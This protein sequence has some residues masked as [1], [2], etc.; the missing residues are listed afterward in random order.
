[1]KKA[2]SNWSVVVAS[3]AQGD[4]LDLFL[5]V[6]VDGVDAEVDTDRQQQRGY[7]DEHLAE[8]DAGQAHEAERPDDSD[9]Q[10]PVTRGARSARSRYAIG[11]NRKMNSTAAG[12]TI[13]RESTMTF[14]N[15]SAI[16]PDPNTVM[17]PGRP[18]S[19]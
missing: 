18:N 11:R 14:E 7:R 5:A 3:P 15:S 17:V 16:I 19:P 2:T 10:G 1:M 6:A 9:Q 8:R 13:S 4:S 12:T